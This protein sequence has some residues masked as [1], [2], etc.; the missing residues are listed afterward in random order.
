MEKQYMSHEEVLQFLKENYKMPRGWSHGNDQPLW[1]K[2][3][4]YLWT[5]MW[6]RCYDPNNGSYPYYI[7]SI[8][9][10]DFRLFS[11]FLSWL[12]QQPRFEEFCSTCHEVK[13]VIDKD[14]K[15]DDNIHYFPDRVTLCTGSE[16]TKARNEAHGNPMSNINTRKRLMIPVIG[17]SKNDNTFIILNFMSE[18]EDK[19]FDPSTISKCCKGKRPSYKGYKWYY[20]DMNDRR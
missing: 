1:H 11:D 15:V 7:N 3:A 9:H 8:I 6:K 13:W 5:D 4:K 19:G 18:W 12:M 16:N 2:K 14:I 10:D 17:I 20:F